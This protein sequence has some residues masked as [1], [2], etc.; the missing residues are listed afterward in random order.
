M[1]RP[2]GKGPARQSPLSVCRRVAAHRKKASVFYL[3]TF[4]ARRVYEAEKDM[5]PG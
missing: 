2:E 5:L 4:S 1:I 3:Y